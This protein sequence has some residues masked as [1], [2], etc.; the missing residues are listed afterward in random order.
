MTSREVVAVIEAVG[1]LLTP[2]DCRAVYALIA[3]RIDNPDGAARSAA[4]RE[5][6]DR[7]W[8]F[9]EAQLLGVDLER[10]RREPA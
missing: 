2:D 8:L 7:E 10:R 4:R 3:S 6:L 9:E 5:R 1:D